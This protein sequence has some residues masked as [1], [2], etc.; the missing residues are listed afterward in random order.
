ME[1]PYAEMHAFPDGDAPHSGNPA[2]VVMLHRDLSDADLL[3][4]AQSNNLSETAYLKPM[5]EKDQWGLRWFTPGLEVELCGHATLASAAWLFETGR[6]VGAEARFHTLSG[7]LKVSR[8]DDGRYQMDFPVIGFEPGKADAAVISAL[9][10][11][12]PDAVYEVERVHG[13]RYQMLVFAD[14]GQVVGLEP[15]IKA[16]EATRTNVIATAPGRAS[17]F[18]SR[19]FGPASGVDEDP[20]TGSAH[21][22]LAPYWFEKLGQSTLKAR[23][24]GPR[25]GALEVRAGSAGRVLLVGQARR[26]LDG[27]IRL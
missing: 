15:D 17:D 20:V 7:L 10:G 9:G 1:F 25:P 22:T 21:C 14:E 4:V 23:Q 16:L 6:V 8:L 19:F 24:V 2:G 5:G 18:V 11:G 13:N 26:Y 3:G 27:V 12:T